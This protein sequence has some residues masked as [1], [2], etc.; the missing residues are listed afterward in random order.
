MAAEAP[1]RSS[2]LIWFIDSKAS[3]FPL[4]HPALPSSPGEANNLDLTLISSSGSHVGW[5]ATDLSGVELVRK[6]P[7][8]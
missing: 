8:L 3:V 6:F 4:Y 7:H 1:S 5:D 2:I